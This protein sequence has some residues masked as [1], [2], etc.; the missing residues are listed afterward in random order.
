MSNKQII[1]IT[2]GDPAGIGPEVT[3]KAIY[4]LNQNQRE[5]ILVIGSGFVLAKNPI[6]RRL[7]FELVDVDNVSR[8]NFAKGK[9]SPSFGHA[10]L[11]Y[12]DK[13]LELLKVRAINALVTAPVSKEA[14][15]LAGFKFSGHTEYLAQKTHTK[16]F[17]MMFVANK[18]KVVLVT[19]HLPLKK[20]PPEINKGK[21][22]ETALLTRNFL[23][24][25]YRIKTPRIAV[26]GLNP[27]AGEDGLFG[28]EEEDI[29]KPA[30][31]QTK[32]QIKFIFGPFASDT[33]FLPS[34]S[35]RFD[36]II[37]MYHDQGMIPVKT[38]AFNSCVNVTLGLPFI[39]TS[40]C[41]GTAFDIAG[42]NKADCSSMLAA[43]KLASSL[44][45][46]SRC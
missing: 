19:R 27:H 23:K 8:A 39:R 21:I 13:G 3:L 14:I 28:K 32:R 36:A 31:A 17:A 22:I 1:G 9:I 42:K 38:L 25:Y 35:K 46:K 20:V 16:K 2:M 18:L 11:E 41:H 45:H 33:L 24:D 15:N 4:R 37:A 30:I 40:P 43:I 26:C 10:A 5:K 12:I 34:Q 44:L 29:I 7:N 6:F